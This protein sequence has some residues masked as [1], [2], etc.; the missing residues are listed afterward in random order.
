MAPPKRTQERLPSG[1]LVE[2]H[3]DENGLK[4]LVLYSHGNEI[5]MSTFYMFGVPARES[6]A[7]QHQPVSR[8]VYTKH[9]AKYPDMP[10]PT[11]G[12]RGLDAMLRDVAR[13]ESGQQAK[14][15]NERRVSKRTDGRAHDEFCKEMM[16][17]G[18]RADAV[19]W[20]KEP[21]HSLGEMTVTASRRLVTRLIG[22]GAVKVHACQIDSYYEVGVDAQENTGHL[23]IELPKAAPRR[24]ALLR[25]VDRLARLQGL[26][27]PPD[28]GQKLVYVKLD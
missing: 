5:V 13:R 22:L 7:Y 16:A 10:P 26:A 18:R 14:K 9:R 1:T 15:K 23:V 6:Y 4:Q 8:A 2:Q 21:E 24:A 25:E 28:D 11:R 12:I 27:G 20:I 3:L 19:V 17:A